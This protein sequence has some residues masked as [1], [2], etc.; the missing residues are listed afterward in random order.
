[1][2]H[3]KSLGGGGVVFLGWTPPHNKEKEGESPKEEYIT[4]LVVM[5]RINAWCSFWFH[6][7]ETTGMGYTS[8]QETCPGQDNGLASGCIGGMR[9]LRPGFGRREGISRMRI[10]FNSTL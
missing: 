8:P 6:F 3:I 10:S 7:E 2:E 5:N 9:G 4:N 1:M